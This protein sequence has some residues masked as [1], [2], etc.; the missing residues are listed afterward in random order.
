[1]HAKNDIILTWVYYY[2]I[3]LEEEIYGFELLIVASKIIL[4]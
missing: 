3:Y 2:I 1:M 4:N